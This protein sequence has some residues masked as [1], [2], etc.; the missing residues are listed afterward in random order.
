ML[1][2]ATGADLALEA[3]E[4]NEFLADFYINAERWALPMQIDFLLSR[5]RQFSTLQSLRRP[6][7]ADHTYAKDR[8]FARTLLSG[9]EHRLYERL[10][11][12]LVSPKA[13]PDLIVYVDADNETLLERIRQRN[14]DFE[15]NI[16][17]DYLDKL[18]SA[19]RDEVLARQGVRFM[20]ED[21]TS[22]DLK[23]ANEMA[24][25]FERILNAIPHG[26]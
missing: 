20:R 6:L 12:T 16:T 1:S 22:L 4:T 18:R 13:L 5:H 11:A 26:H 24:T 15:A 25:V 17:G 10:H 8:A 3:Y 9:R 7:V 19:Y 23:S 2:E 21:T 14:R